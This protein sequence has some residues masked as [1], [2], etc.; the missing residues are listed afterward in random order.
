MYYF[1]EVMDE[2]SRDDSVPLEISAKRCPPN[3]FMDAA[4]T[5]FALHH[6]NIEKNIL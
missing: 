4:F 3:L 2:D 6:E 5:E 1:E